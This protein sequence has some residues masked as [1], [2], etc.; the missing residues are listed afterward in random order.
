MKR[1]EVDRQRLSP[2]MQQYLNVK[3]KYEDAII[4]FRLGDFYEMFFEDALLCSRELE[5]TLTGKQAGLKERIPMC[6]V[7]YHAYRAYV[8]K[9]IN[10]GYKVA[11]CEQLTDPKESKG[12]VDRDVVQVI[13]KGTILDNSLD[14][15]ENNYIGN[16]YDFDY[17]YGISFTDITTG[18][19]YV[20][21]A[22]N[23]TNLLNIVKSYN[24]KEIIVNSNIDREIINNLREFN[25][26]LVTYQDN[27]LENN[28]YIQVYENLEDIRMVNTIKHLLF[29]I[30]ETKKDIL[31]HLQSAE[32]LIM[33]EHLLFDIYTKKN[34]ELVQTIRQQDKTYSLLWLLDKTKTAMGAR[35][36]KYNIENPLVNKEEII[37]RHNI[38]EK[39][40]T[41]FI[42]R[43]E[44]INAL[45]E[46][47]DLERLSSRISY[48]NL[49]ARDLIQLKDSLKVLPFIDN[50]LEELKYDKK[51]ETF[52]DLYELLDQTI[53]EDAPITIKEGSIIKDE[54]GYERKQTLSNCERF[55]TPLLKEKE[56]IILGA[57]EKIIDLEYHLFINIR[58]I[59]K[60]YIQRLQVTSK[61]LA[62]IDMLQS[63]TIA[64]EN[65]SYVKPEITDERIIN[66]KDARHPVVEKVLKNEYVPNDIVMDDDVNILLITGP[67]MAG[68]STY[69][70]QLAIIVIM[71]QI[72][73]YVPCKS[74]KIPL[75]DKIFTRIGASDDLVSGE[76]TFMIEMKEANMAI[77]E[78]TTNSLLLFD[79]LGRGTATYDGMSL[80]QA[81][82]EYIHDYIKAKTLFSTHY[83]ELTSLSNELINL[84]NIHVSAIERE[85][86]ITFLH[87]IKKGA[88]DKSYGIHVAALAKLPNEI[89]K[90]AND[91]LAAYE[92][93]SIRKKIF[94][95]TSLFIEEEQTTT[96]INNLTSK[97]NEIDP[98]NITPL[99]ALNKVYELKELIKDKND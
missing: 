88:V 53:N 76:S 45:D 60:T 40:L 71:N 44:L 57:E 9:L 68:K 32:V 17:C 21:I 18:Y 29:Y 35:L 7:P 33:N 8:E 3:D 78:A 72:G 26:I 1:S 81:I 50:I 77:A 54:F 65:N 51:I 92:N 59:V 36:L 64:A 89:I 15:K 84:K 13:T 79:E 49:N 34:L 5:L 25:N 31:K 74:C 55:I 69:M 61:I 20:T 30:N 56:N 42:F 46:V 19:F 62:E 47:Y 91:I 28:D 99:Q 27:I 75:F 82:L 14:A 97:L 63:L 12:V 38:I 85:G 6:G 23:T 41:E 87:K 4:F 37:R 52:P 66:I 73:S 24:I 2:M 10:Q 16:I 86:E 39:L 80:A 98:L 93:K 96:V 58:D 83:H 95:Q 70:R 43:E 22:E 94:T 48:G 11:I 67:N 90:R